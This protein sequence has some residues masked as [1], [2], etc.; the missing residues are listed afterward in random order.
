MKEKERI[1][2]TIDNLD[3]LSSVLKSI[4]LLFQKLVNYYQEKDY[5]KLCI[6]GLSSYLWFKKVVE[7]IGYTEKDLQEL[8]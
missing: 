5:K 8:E 2:I 7:W 4:E 1:A 6:L 3:D